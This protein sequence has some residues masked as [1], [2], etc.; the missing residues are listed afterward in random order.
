MLITK[1]KAKVKQRNIRGTRHKNLPDGQY[2]AAIF[3][4][5]AVSEDISL[6]QKAYVITDRKFSNTQQLLPL[7][8]SEVFIILVQINHFGEKENKEVND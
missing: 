5:A 4:V 2:V 8:Y 7:L 1:A 3:V 6:R